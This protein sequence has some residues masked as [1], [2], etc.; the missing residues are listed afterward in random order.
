MD[1]WEGLSKLKWFVLNVE[2]WRDGVSVQMS[3]VTAVLFRTD[4]VPV[5]HQD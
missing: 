4:R 2:A 5:R 3:R 1:G